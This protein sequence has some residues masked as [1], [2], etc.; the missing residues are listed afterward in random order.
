VGSLT[1]MG[2]LRIGQRAEDRSVR[3][4]DFVPLAELSDLVFGGRNVYDDNVFKAT[5]AKILEPLLL[6]AVKDELAAIRPMT[7]ATDS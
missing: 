6:H 1:Q 4:K 3:I 5:K 2:S 7:A